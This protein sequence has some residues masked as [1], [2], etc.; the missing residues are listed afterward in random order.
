MCISIFNWRHFIIICVPVNNFRL[1]HEVPL[2]RFLSSALCSIG[3]MD[4]RGSNK[5][6]QILVSLRLSPSGR[7]SDKGIVQKRRQT[8]IKDTVK[9]G[10]Q[11]RPNWRVTL[12]NETISFHCDWGIVLSSGNDCYLGRAQSSWI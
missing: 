12:A 9:T 10:H 2:G 11:Q 1:S 8:A 6:R 3:I 5:F 7:T 4:R